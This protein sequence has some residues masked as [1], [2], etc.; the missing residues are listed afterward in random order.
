MQWWF[1]FFSFS[2]EIRCTQHKSYISIL[3]MGTGITKHEHNLGAELFW[4]GAS[5]PKTSAPGC[6][7]SNK[8]VSSSL[9]VW[10][11]TPFG[12]PWACPW[13]H[14]VILYKSKDFTQQICLRCMQLLIS[15]FEV[16]PVKSYGTN[17][18]MNSKVC[19]HWLV[20]TQWLWDETAT[21]LLWHPLKH[22]S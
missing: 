16:D 22:F 14:T 3:N 7:G 21:P 8:H 1:S 10:W 19:R 5:A 18:R 12:L 13:L 20:H 2:P 6:L 15:N 9:V 11:F 17:N 4:H